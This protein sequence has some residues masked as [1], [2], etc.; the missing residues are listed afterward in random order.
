MI[1]EGVC[2]K[3]ICPMSGENPMH[4]LIAKCDAA[5]ILKMGFSYFGQHPKFVS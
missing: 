3:P 4:C 1:G 5:Q 2:A